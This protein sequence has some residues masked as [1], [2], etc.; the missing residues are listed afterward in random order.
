MKVSILYGLPLSAPSQTQLA[1]KKAHFAQ[2]QGVRK[3]VERVF[4]VLQARFAVVRGRAKQWDPDTLW[5]AVTCCVIMHNMIVE[6]EGDNA[7]ATLEF[8][9]MGYPIQLPNQN[10]ATVEEFIQMHNKF[11]I[12]QHTSS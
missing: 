4:G 5:E 10:P 7:T 11:G 9:N 12:D 3:G 1:R 2:R 8:D 6:N